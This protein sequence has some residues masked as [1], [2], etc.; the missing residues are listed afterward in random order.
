[1]D[2]PDRNNDAFVIG[3]E[4]LNVGL[5]EDRWTPQNAS[6]TY[7]FLNFVQAEGTFKIGSD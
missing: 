1:M 5:P 3:A 7:L 4:P 2:P 6:I